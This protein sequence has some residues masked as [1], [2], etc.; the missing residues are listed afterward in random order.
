MIEDLK[1]IHSKF[2]DRLLNFIMKK[3]IVNPRFVRVPTSIFLR[4]K[5]T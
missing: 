5:L 2:C 1:I 3:F 4:K